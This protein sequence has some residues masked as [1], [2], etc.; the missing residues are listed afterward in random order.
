METLKKKQRKILKNIRKEEFA[1]GELFT[2][3]LNEISV[4]SE[5][6]VIYAMG[7]FGRSFRNFARDID[8]R[9]P[10]LK[11]IFL[12]ELVNGGEFSRI[13]TD[14]LKLC[15]Y[16]KTWGLSDSVLKSLKRSVTSNSTY[17]ELN[18]NIDSP[19]LNL[20]Y[21]R[22]VKTKTFLKSYREEKRAQGMQLI[23]PRDVPSDFD[24]YFYGV[25]KY[26]NDIKEAKKRIARLADSGLVSMAE[27]IEIGLNTIIEKSKLSQYMG[28]NQINLVEAA[29]I[30]GNM[31]GCVCSLDK[32]II[33]E[34]TFEGQ[35]EC[36]YLPRVYP[37]HDLEDIASD[38]MKSLMDYLDEY[39]PLGR[40]TLFD[41]FRV[42][43]PGGEWQESIGSLAHSSKSG[44][45]LSF[46][47]VLIGQKRIDETLIQKG[48]TAILLGERDGEHYFVSYWT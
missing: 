24:D 5:E 44:S 13:A 28:F 25:L 33:P 19:S 6:E 38:E 14:H 48:M 34:G 36:R 21:L 45:G 2:G 4:H 27:E 10:D 20:R 12:G 39:P 31:I 41:H 3:V 23:P 37:Y 18:G 42:L 9:H 15:T 32:Y 8:L 40:R 7:D 11:S 26:E 35:A 30:L 47:D 29:V 43:V 16:G 17:K 46:P 22:F 1:E